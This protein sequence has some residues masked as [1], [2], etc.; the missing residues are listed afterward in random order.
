MYFEMG[1]LGNLMIEYSRD[2]EILTFIYEHNM[3]AGVVEK[4]VG[5]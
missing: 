2:S 5:F 4:Y 3:L 1:M